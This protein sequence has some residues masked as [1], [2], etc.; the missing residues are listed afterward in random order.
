MWSVKGNEHKDDRV[1]LFSK[2]IG[3]SPAIETLPDS[4]FLHYVSFLRQ[5]NFEMKSLFSKDLKTELWV[6]YMRVKKALKDQMHDK[7]DV[8]ALNTLYLQLCKVTKV[9]AA[10]KV[11]KDQIQFDISIFEAYRS[12]HEKVVKSSKFKTMSVMLDIL[13]REY[14]DD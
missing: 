12:L 9:N 14:E 7:F 1:K 5:T 6:P 4:I 13:F 3:L 11:L 10:S 2:L 8:F